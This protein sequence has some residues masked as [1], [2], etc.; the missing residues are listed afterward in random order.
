MA[1]PSGDRAH[2][3]LVKN[4]V[5]YEIEIDL[6]SPHATADL[7]FEHDTVTQPSDNGQ[8][9]ETHTTGGVTVELKAYGKLV[10]SERRQS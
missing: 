7:S 6:T 1:A 8:W 10:K 5:T 2:I 3:V 9:M 4:G